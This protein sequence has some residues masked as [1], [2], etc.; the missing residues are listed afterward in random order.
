[1]ALP[2]VQALG[3]TREGVLLAGTSRGLFSLKG[4]LLKEDR[5]WKAIDV[6][7]HTRLPVMAIYSSRA[8]VAIQ[9]KFGW[10]ISTDNGQVWKEWPMPSTA[11]QVNEVALSCSGSALA[12]T[13]RG[14][15]RFSPAGSNPTEVK[16]IPDGTVSAVTFDPLNCQTAYAA[17][18]G[19]AYISRDDGQ[20]W[21]ALGGN[22][23]Q[24]GAIETLRVTS[25]HELAALFRNEGVFKLDLPDDHF[26]TK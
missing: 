2:D 24:S 18:F 21:T 17:R 5:T 15:V 6:D 19:K 3:F 1:V 25:S 4:A 13:S 26:P 8:S 14:L 22:G 11:G 7:G 23:A 9:T 16:G 10:Y 12:A 20:T